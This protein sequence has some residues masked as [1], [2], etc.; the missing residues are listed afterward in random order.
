MKLFSEVPLRLMLALTAI[1]LVAQSASALTFKTKNSSEHDDV[2]RRTPVQMQSSPIDA[3]TL[4]NEWP[5]KPSNKLSL[6]NRQHL[7]DE[8][9][10]D[11]FLSGGQAGRCSEIGTSDSSPEQLASCIHVVAL[12]FYRS[13]SMAH[14]EPTLVNIA[15]TDPL[16][17]VT[18][19][20]DF[21]PDR[22]NA[23]AAM[24]VYGAFYAYYYDFFDF[25]SET[26]QLVDNYFERKLT[27]LNM[28]AVGEYNRQR[29]CDPRKPKRIGLKTDGRADINTCESNRWKATIAQL[30]LGMRLK[31]ETLF[32]R[33][34]YNTK[35]MLLFFDDEGIFIPWAVRGALA[36]HYSNEVPRFLSKL[37]EIYHALGYDFLEHELETGL[38]VKDIYK[39]YFNIYDNKDILNKY[40]KRRYAEKGESYAQYQKRSTEEELRRWN[41]TKESF[42]RESMRYITSY[43]P[44]LESLI[45]CDFRLRDENN[46][47]QRLVSSFSAID[48]YE[49]FLANF[50][51]KQAPEEHCQKFRGKKNQTEINQPVEV[52]SDVQSDANTQKA[53]EPKV[54]GDSAHNAGG[55]QPFRFEFAEDEEPFSLGQDIGFGLNYQHQ[56]GR[57]FQEWGATVSTDI[58]RLGD[59]ALKFE[60]REG[61]CGHNSSWSDCDNGRQRH[62]FGS[63]YSANR[64]AFNLNEEYWHAISVY[65]PRD[66]TF[67]KPVNTGI[68]QFFAPPTGAWMFH[69]SDTLGFEVVNSS[70]GPDHDEDHRDSVLVLP[71]DFVGKW[72]D[73]VIQ[74]NHSRDPDGY[75]KVWVNGDLVHDYKGISTRPSGT[76]FFKFG[77]YKTATP[78]PNPDYNNGANFEDMHVFYDE[79]RFAEACEDLVLDDLGYSCEKLL[80]SEFKGPNYQNEKAPGTKA[81]ST[82]EPFNKAGEWS[83]EDLSVYGP[84]DQVFLI[85]YFTKLLGEAHPGL[86]AEDIAVFPGGKTA[87]N[88]EAISPI[89]RFGDNS[90][91]GVEKDSKGSGRDALDIRLTENGMLSISGRMQLFPG[92]AF[93]RVGLKALAPNGEMEIP[94]YAGDKVFIRWKS[95]SDSGTEGEQEFAV[96]DSKPK[97]DRTRAGLS[98]RFECLLTALTDIG[99]ESLPTD[100]E[101]DLVI[102]GL[103]GNKFYRTKRHLEKLGMSKDA[104]K[105]HKA[106]LLRLVNFEG[107]NEA[108]CAKPVR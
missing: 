22:Y 65:V 52:A 45:A 98:M 60:T 19:A 93:I 84:D 1:F 46:E 33:G 83:P 88:K 27:Y 6:I 16:T 50:S 29:F 105:A 86:E 85:S 62:E 59:R 17:Y 25:D 78:I 8:L 47:P 75:M 30:L 54:D 87:T 69:Y 55:P 20:N 24:T 34:I 67:A 18:R 3:L 96:Q 32:Q 26:R 76:P 12:E 79:I 99:E 89:L 97:Y 74:A 100:Q 73:I 82:T 4:P 103:E 48:S 37:T 43:R 40:A 23:R 28:D 13:G 92:E 7:S 94:Y 38:R 49:L 21:S 58:V 56:M 91:D 44:D 64:K 9:Q 15:K 42:A 95:V 11:N 80:Q 39:T 107:T 63:R 57:T 68:F 35:F 41:L 51:D 36:L 2:Q 106:S 101:I 70:H 61:F 10:D 81:F 71:E 31:N 14:F 102:N 108:F 90:E 66:I 53:T 77:I 104:V 5:F 72:N